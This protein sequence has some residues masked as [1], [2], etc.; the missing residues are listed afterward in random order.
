MDQP[1]VTVEEQP[2]EQTMCV[3]DTSY[4]L[5]ESMVSGR[6]SILSPAMSPRVSINPDD[7]AK[8]KEDRI[9]NKNSLKLRLINDLGQIR[10]TSKMREKEKLLRKQLAQ[11]KNRTLRQSEK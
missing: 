6:S 3:N 8:Q 9:R 10:L 7:A 2:I 4:D 5:D 1:R 11:Q